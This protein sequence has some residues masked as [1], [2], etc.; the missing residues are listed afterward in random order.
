MYYKFLQ[1]DTF[2]GIVRLTVGG[3]QYYEGLNSTGK[4]NFFANI[5]T[6]L[7]KIIIINDDRLSLNGKTQVDYSIYPDRQI[8]ISLDIESSN[9]ERSVSAIVEDL[10]AIII[11]NDVSPILSSPTTKYLDNTYGY[12]QSEYTT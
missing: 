10:R 4:N 11:N 6:E 5:R 2:Y 3:T 8:L 12:N 1:I 9:E 7:S